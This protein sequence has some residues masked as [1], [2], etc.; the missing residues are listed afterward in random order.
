MKPGLTASGL[1]ALVWVHPSGRSSSIVANQML[2]SDAATGS[3]LFGAVDETKYQGP[4]KTAP[5]VQSPNSLDVVRTAIQ[6]TSLTLEDKSGNSS[7]IPD[8]SVVWAT[9]DTGASICEAPAEIVDPIYAAA[10]V[11]QDNSTRG[12]PLIPCNMS[13]AD[14]NFTFGFGGPQ[15]PQISVSIKDFVQPLPYNVTFQDG[16][17]ACVFGVRS[18]PDPMLLLGDTFLRSAYAVFD[19]SNNQIALAQ[20][21]TDTANSL[22]QSILPIT[23]GKDG[24]PGVVTRVSSILWPQPYSTS[25]NAYWASQTAAAKSGKPTLTSSTANAAAAATTTGLIVPEL[26]PKA[27]FTAEGPG[28]IRIGNVTVNSTGSPARPTVQP[29]NA[30]AGIKDV[31][32][33]AGVAAF[34]FAM[35]VLATL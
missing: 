27:S 10:G 11:L 18:S 31:G 25:Y 2:I 17:P 5:I 1:M 16:S 22:N 30:N 19:L 21:Q 29:A 23:K 20:S 14:A 28:L 12:F 13:T 8:G 26:P 6:L 33:G 34:V 3:I 9:L 32:V 15:G 4:L 7:L 35:A 24:I